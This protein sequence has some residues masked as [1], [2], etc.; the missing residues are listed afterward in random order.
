MERARYQ[1][2]HAQLN[3]KTPSAKW[4]LYIGYDC[5]VAAALYWGL[6]Y[7]GVILSVLA[8]FF[9]A[10]VMF[11]AF[12]FMHEAVHGVLHPSKKINEWL[13]L[14]WGTLCFLPYAQW[15]SGHLEHHYW[16]GNIEKDPVMKLC[17]Y[18]KNGGKMPWLVELGWRLWIPVLA[19][20]QE[21]VFWWNSF[22]LLKK[23]N[24]T[25]MKMVSV[26]APILFWG[27]LFWLG[28]G[29]LF[30]TLYL[31]AILIYLAMVEIVNLPHHL[32]LP[33]FD[34]ETR[35]PV[36]NQH[37]I[38]RS[39][40]YPKWFERWALLNFNY[41]VEHHLFPTLPWSELPK[42]HA[43]MEKALG[44]QYNVEAGFTWIF[45]N[46]KRPLANVIYQPPPT[47]EKSQLESA[48]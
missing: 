40:T 1:Q 3:F 22:L 21:A 4:P 48:A 45:R 34:H 32:E 43:L 6:A 7:G 16:A 39:C 18:V 20:L 10:V 41:H 13:G 29:S 11:R 25:P 28:G 47:I 30:L 26:I 31:P 37:Q 14:Y 5:V 38:S 17:L 15:K 33:Q 42:A 8:P 44:S 9:L 24:V 36:F 27:A 19:V 12:G 23:G 46:R 2:I 35:I